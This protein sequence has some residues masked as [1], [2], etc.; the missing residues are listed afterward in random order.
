MIPCVGLFEVFQLRILLYVMTYRIRGTSFSVIVETEDQVEL[1]FTR[2]WDPSLK[3]KLV[4][5]NVD[6]RFCT[7]LQNLAYIP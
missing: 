5:L 6:K 1:S 3:G 4:P 7:L 2:T